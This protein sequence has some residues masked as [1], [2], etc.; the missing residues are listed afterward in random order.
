[1]SLH[2]ADIRARL[3]RLLDRKQMPKRLEGKGGAMEDEIRALTAAVTEIDVERKKSGDAIDDNYLNNF[4]GGW[5]ACLDH[6]L[7]KYP[8]VFADGGKG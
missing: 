2:E 3:N 8:R 6:L 5:N 4:H 1:M 7:S